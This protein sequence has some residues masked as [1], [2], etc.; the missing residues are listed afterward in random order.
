[1]GQQQLL[2]LVIGIIVVAIA[3]M[4]GLYAVE[5][6]FKQSI[7]D[8]LVDRNLTIATDA[9]FWKTKRDPFNGGN[10]Q[11]TGL[12]TDGMQT[13]FL[14]EETKQGKFKITL[15]TANRLEITA[16][17]LRYPEIGV[18][19]YVTDYSIDSTVISYDSTI[20]F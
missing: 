6:K 8:N 19:T 5:T 9:V 11:Y 10:A 20:T 17:S 2:L 3:V 1:M 16:V 15:A 14:G 12:Q 18:R 4:A 13:L 7:A